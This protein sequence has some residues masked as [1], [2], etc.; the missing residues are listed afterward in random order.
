MNTTLSAIEY[1]GLEYLLRRMVS[2][3]E[4]E[5]GLEHD[6]SIRS[7]FI[8][9]PTGIEFCAGYPIDCFSVQGVYLQDDT[10]I[11]IAY[12][13]NLLSGAYPIYIDMTNFLNKDEF[14]IELLIQGMYQ[15]P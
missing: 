11:L 8:R 9:T 2:A 6:D 15:H 4:I 13:Q 1:E 10:T 5:M 12:R 14:E 7:K 3:Y